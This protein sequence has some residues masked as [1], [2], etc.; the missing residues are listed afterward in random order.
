[1]GVLG[2]IRGSSDAY[3]IHFCHFEKLDRN[4]YKTLLFLHS[5]LFVIIGSTFTIGNKQIIVF[6]KKYLVSLVFTLSICICLQN[7]VSAQNMYEV[8]SKLNVR[9][10]PNTSSRVLGVLSPKSQVQ[11]F[12]I[13]DGW[14]R[15]NYNEQESYISSKYIVKIDINFQQGVYRVVTNSNLN[16]RKGP[17]TNSYVLGSLTPGSRIEVVSISEQWAKIQFNGQTGYVN[18]RYIEKEETEEAPEIVEQ[19]TVEDSCLQMQEV[20]VEEIQ[21]VEERNKRFSIDF[22]PEVFHGYSNFIVRDVSPIPSIGF[23]V[24]FP[25]Q[26]LLKQPMLFI[27]ENYFMEVSLG[28]SKKGSNKFGL[29]YFNIKLLPF[30]YKYDISGVSLYGKLGVYTGFTSSKIKTEQNT[31]YP[32]V[33]FGVKAAIGAEYKRIGFSISYEQGFTNVSSAKLKM[34]NTGV[35]L[36]VSYRVFSLDL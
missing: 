15:I 30:C 14:A 26:F 28:Y 17:S 2:V 8:V 33:D 6:M 10:Q 1:M 18:V 29:H 24:D 25:V 21:V 16:V 7:N 20:E 31:F 4:E 22:T 34:K 19:D 11:V 13:S 36:N 3:I 27:P 32:N 35:F 12:E 9:E 5:I 23:G